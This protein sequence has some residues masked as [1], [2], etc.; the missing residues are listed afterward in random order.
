M[1]GGETGIVASGRWQNEVMSKGVNCCEGSGSAKW[2][3]VVT[4]G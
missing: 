1:V 2:I 3:V 4:G